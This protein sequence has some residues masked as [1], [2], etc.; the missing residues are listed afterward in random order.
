MIK[1]LLVDDH[2]I[3]RKGLTSVFEQ[4]DDFEVIGEASGGK[5]ALSFIESTK[6]DIVIMDVMMPN[7]NGVDVAERIKENYPEIKV[8]M[9]SAFY[10][11]KTVEKAIRVDA[12]GYMLKDSLSD[13][14]IKVVRIIIGGDKFIHPVAAKR[15]MNNLGGIS[16]DEPKKEH[17]LTPRELKV[18]KLI[19]DGNTNHEIA[20]KLYLGDE[21]V[22]T[23]VKNIYLK[24]GVS[25]RIEAVLFAVKNNI[26]SLSN[27]TIIEDF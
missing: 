22:K 12:D 16:D 27:G 10:D 25:N 19:C 1:I 18:L 2:E 13:D 26:I 8:M 24:I 6:P 14:L 15:M 20:S 11:F 21:T 3:L 5:E 4:V 17:N 9:L 23:H 7:E